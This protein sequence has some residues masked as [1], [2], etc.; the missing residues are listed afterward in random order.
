MIYD[1]HIAIPTYNRPQ[2]L[3]DK[4]LSLLSS[5]PK[6][7]I[8][9]YVEDDEQEELYKS[10]VKRFKIIKTYT[11]GI[12]EKRNKIKKINKAKWLFQIDDDISDIIDFNNN[13]LS[14]KQVWDLIIKGFEE[15]NKIPNCRLWGIAG[16]CNHFFLKDTITTN[17]KFICGN[18]HGTIIDDNRDI[19]LT[20][21]DLMEDYFN[22]L[23][24]F[25]QDKVV[26]R[27]NGYGTKTKFFK[28]EG[29]LQSFYM[30][31]ERINKEKEN[32]I[33]LKKNYGRMCR[34]IEKKRGYDLR[35]NYRF[36]Y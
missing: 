15:C 11:N 4:T 3:I 2:I 14:P 20:P 30:S 29:G 36:N 10:V 18:F 27:I 16:F 6:E 7:Y 13:K 21:I 24:H 34:I 32:A 35:L 8:T 22:T 25:K 33:W 1:L 12:G 5:V 31:D 26:L 23:E 9:I 17:L 19:I 28:E